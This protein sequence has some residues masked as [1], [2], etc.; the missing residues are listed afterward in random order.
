MKKLRSSRIVRWP[1]AAFTLVELL[2]VIAIIGILIAL[3]LP[4]VQAARE[5]ARRSQCTNNLKQIGLALHNYHDS[6]KRF[7][8][9]GQGTNT[10]D[11]ATSTMGGLSAF[12]MLLPYLEQTSIYQQFS[13]PQANPPYPAWG[14]VPWYGWNFR[15]HHVQVPSILCPSDGGAGKLQDDGRPYWWQGDNNY[16]FCWGDDISVDWRGRANPRGIFGGDSFLSFS[17]IL[18]GTSNTLAASEVVVSKRSDDRVTHGNYVENV[19]DGNL[20]QNPSQCLAFKG[21]NNT[22]V[23]APQIG[24]LRGVN[25]AW[26]TSVVTGFNTVLPPNSIG[27]KGFWSEWGSDHVM[28]PDSYHP[29]GVN[30]LLADGSVRFISETINTGDLT[31][32]EPTGGPS[33]YGVWGALGSRAGSESISG[34]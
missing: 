19:G 15:P 16:V 7:P 20:R 9:L 1:S 30:A 3:L 24:E 5:A 4:A 10:G 33:P 8:S 22:I 17:D 2:V 21:P 14:P 31:R 12:V 6:H 23:N 25:W 34:F 18:D 11:P 29:G 26:G 27:C 28:P 32:P 13:S